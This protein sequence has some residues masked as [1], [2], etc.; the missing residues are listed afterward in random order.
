MKNYT[1]L[2]FLLLFKA[3]PVWAVTEI[4]SAQV[5][6]DTVVVDSLLTMKEE[7]VQIEKPSPKVNRWAIV[8]V[9]TSLIGL[10]S[11]VLLVFGGI[12]IPGAFFL[13]IAGILFGIIGLIKINKRK[14][15]GKGLAI[16]G[17]IIAVLPILLLAAI[18]ILFLTSDS[19]GI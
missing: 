8:S 17:I 9:I 15:R 19:I 4:K 18:L 6:V 10:A 13:L 11:I 5:S 3:L 1:F 12:A 2:F 16:L 7:V 14:Q